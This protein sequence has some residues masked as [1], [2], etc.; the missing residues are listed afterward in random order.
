M[1]ILPPS[2]TAIYDNLNSVMNLARVRMNDAIRS[3]G[4]EVMT[5]NAAFTQTAVNGAWRVMCEY[6]AN[7]GY[8]RLI[9]DQVIGPLP[10]VANSDPAIQTW[11]S[12]SGY[13][14]G[15]NEYDSPALPSDFISPLKMWERQYGGNYP[16]PVH[17]NM[18]NIV[19]GLPAQ[20]KQGRNYVWE[21]RED[22]IYMPGSLT[23][24]DIRV[25]YAKYLGDFVDTGD[26]VDGNGTYWYNQLVPIARCQSPFAK[27]I[28]Y[29]V[30]APRGD[31]DAGIF[32]AEAENEA[33]MIFN[34]D[35]KMKSR[36]NLRRQPR[37]GRTG[38]GYGGNYGWN[39]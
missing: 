14:D 28:C 29:E 16:F 31:M 21:W 25:R 17:P 27:F 1:P 32:K 2:N 13:F 26:P 33:K 15:A 24:M 9:G 30:A 22:A 10:R 3:L 20:P 37:S 8:T 4:G 23:E 5:N 7:L 12:W 39:G 18:E 6:L 11:L 35:V 36:V 19:D 38:G 34:R